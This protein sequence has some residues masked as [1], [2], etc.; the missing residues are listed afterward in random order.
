[1]AVVGAGAL[2]AVVAVVFALIAITTG[3]MG[4]PAFVVFMPVSVAAALLAGALLLGRPGAR[5]MLLSAGGGLALTV[6]AAL[7]LIGRGEADGSQAAS[8][9]LAVAS[10]AA[11][12]YSGLGWRL[13]CRRSV[14]LSPTKSPRLGDSRHN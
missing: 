3:A 1:M 4:V 10:A 2:W 8:I 5:T 6:L 11:A 9:T 14:S 12:I 7:S 13:M